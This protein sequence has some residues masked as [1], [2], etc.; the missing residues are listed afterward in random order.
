MIYLVVDSQNVTSGLGLLVLKA[1]VFR[2][3]GI[4]Y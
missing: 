1:S 3:N 4:I 2:D